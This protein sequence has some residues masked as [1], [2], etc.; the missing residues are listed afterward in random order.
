VP[1][2]VWQD[3]SKWSPKCVYVVYLKGMEFALNNALVLK[4]AQG[5]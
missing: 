5:F 2:S 3:H 1:D 4:T